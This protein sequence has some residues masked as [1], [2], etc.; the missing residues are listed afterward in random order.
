LTGEGNWRQ[1]VVEIGGGFN[2]YLLQFGR[3][4]LWL[5]SLSMRAKSSPSLFVLAF[6]FIAVSHG[7]ASAAL[8][9]VEGGPRVETADSDSEL[10]STEVA[11]EEDKALRPLIDPPWW[12]YLLLFVA[13]VG[14]LVWTYLRKRWIRI[15]LIGTIIA[16][17]VS[18]PGMHIVI[19]PIGVDIKLWEVEWWIAAVAGIAVIALAT[20]EWPYSQADYEELKHKKAGARAGVMRN[21][22]RLVFEKH[23]GR[24]DSLEDIS[25]EHAIDIADLYAAL[26]CATEIQSLLEAG[27]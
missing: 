10:T 27:E 17:L 4:L 18:I 6:L 19:K 12:A 5:E 2:S 13:I 23:L 9:R 25:S 26:H 20:L 24:G 16:G 7:I 3:V 1:V 21:A 15:G 11:T 8:Q 14:V 22:A